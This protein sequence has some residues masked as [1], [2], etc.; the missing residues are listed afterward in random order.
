MVQLQPASLRYAETVAEHLKQNNG[1]GPGRGNQLSDF[2]AGKV[3][4][5]G[6]GAGDRALF[7]RFSRGHLHYFVDTFKLR[8]TPNPLSTAG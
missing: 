5:P 1:R 4:A 6:L 7:G 2:K 8:K 3:V